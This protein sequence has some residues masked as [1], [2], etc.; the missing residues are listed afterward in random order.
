[1]MLLVWLVPALFFV[2]LAL[3]AAYVHAR[4]LRLFARTPRWP[5]RIAAMVGVVGIVGSIAV[6]ATSASGMAGYIYVAA[7]HLLTLHLFLLMALLVLHGLQKLMPSRPVGIG[8][9][10]VALAFTVYGAINASDFRVQR[11]SIQLAG[12]E[13]PVTLMLIS[14]VHIGHHRDGRYLARIVDETNRSG[15]EL[16]LITGDLLDSEVAFAPG[17]LDALRS[18]KAPAY[19]VIGNHEIDVDAARATALISSLGV[20]VLHN[21]RVQT[22]GLDLLGLDYMKADEAAFDLHPSD[23]TETIRSVL[24]SMTL[25]SGRPTVA[26]H[27][28]PVGVPYLEQAGVDL[29]VA[30]HTHGGQLFPGTAFAALTF[31]YN[32]GLH[33]GPTQVFVSTGAG[34]FLQKGRIGTTNEINLI[35][36]V[37]AP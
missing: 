17:N 2:A 24:E 6:T 16:V 26:M 25:P 7:G 8:A 14:D 32:K 23:K 9:L 21:E 13:R 30:G 37:P 31:P 33:D 3:S 36:L 29:L 35:T 27:H 19:Y 1:M 28:S 5:G 4:L 12:L 18:L 15:A 10:T 34:T 11:S 22:H 20:R